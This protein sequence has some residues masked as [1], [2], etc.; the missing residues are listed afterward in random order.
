MEQELLALIKA[1]TEK[2]DLLGQKVESVQ[3][4]QIK[5]ASGKQLGYIVDLAAKAG[6]ETYSIEG[7]TI[8]VKALKAITAEAA[9]AAIKALGGEDK[10]E[11]AAT[12]AAKPATGKVVE[13]EF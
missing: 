4:A 12:P 1:L 2:V 5:R 9:S 13:V 7:V 10:K 6:L 8:P 11:T 3:E